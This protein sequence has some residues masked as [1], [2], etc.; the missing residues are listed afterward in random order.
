MWQPYL[1][2]IREKCLQVLHILDRFHIMAKM[3]K[4]LDEVRAGEIR[5]LARD[6]L[7]SLLGALVWACTVGSV[8]YLGGHALT[9]L[10]GDIRRH[11]KAIAVV[12]AVSVAGLI[13]WRTHGRELFGAWSLRRARRAAL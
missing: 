8:G 2:V 1:D 9:I 7:Q 12:V 10:I 5:K 4:A 3:N 11:E 6:G 13:L